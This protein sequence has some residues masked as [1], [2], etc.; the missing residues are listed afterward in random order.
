MLL[1]QHVVSAKRLV[2]QLARQVVQLATNHAKELLTKVNGYLLVRE[3]SRF[4]ALSFLS[5]FFLF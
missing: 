2:N 5:L 4:T 3:E 1:A